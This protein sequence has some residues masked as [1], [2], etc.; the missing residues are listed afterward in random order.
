MGKNVAIT[1]GRVVLRNQLVELIQYAPVTREVHAEP[2]LIVPSWIM[3][4]YI[5]D[6]SPANSLVRYLVE[7]GH[8][9]F[10]VSWKNPEVK[11]RELGMDDYLK[12]GVLAALDAVKAIIPGV[13]INLTRL[14][15]RRDALRDRGGEARARRARR[16]QFAQPARDPGRL[17]RTRRAVALHRRESDHLSRGHHVGPGVPERRPDGRSVRA[18]QLAGPH[19]VTAGARL[20]ARQASS[21][22]RSHGVECGQHAHAVSHACG[23]SAAAVPGERARSR[24]LRGGRPAGGAHGHPYADLRCVGR[25]ATTFLPGT[26]CSGSTC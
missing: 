9:V 12:L 24:P 2:I 13:P 19:L 5:L 15:P 23:V 6:L 3:K 17:R 26:R 10:M 7:Q 21:G 18:A 1:P 25:C 20:S 22:Q 14:L 16:P 11:D 8:T 4:Y